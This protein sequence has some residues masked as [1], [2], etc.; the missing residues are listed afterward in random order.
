MKNISNW[1][2]QRLSKPKGYVNPYGAADI[3][4]QDVLKD[5]IDVQYMGAAEYEWGALPECLKVMWDEPLRITETRINKQSIWIVHP[6]AM[7]VQK[8]YDESPVRS[9]QEYITAVVKVYKAAQPLTDDESMTIERKEVSKA[10]FGSF[11]KAMVGEDDRTTGW[12][13]I[14]HFFAWFIDEEMATEFYNH[15]NQDN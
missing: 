1:I 5:V 4:S 6:E 13:N 10:D 3:K 12:L 7:K 15:L 2:V 9:F 8:H 14:R 11:Y